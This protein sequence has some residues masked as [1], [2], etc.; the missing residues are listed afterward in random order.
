MRAMLLAL[1]PLGLAA[2]S[3]TVV[4]NPRVRILN[5]NELPHQP[6]KLHKHDFNRVMIYL[7]TADQD[8]S[9]PDA[10]TEHM[11]WKAGDVV[12]SPAG[13]MHMAENVSAG[14]CASWKS[15]SSSPRRR[16]LP[17]APA[18]STRS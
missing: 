14:L 4:D 7:D 6:T 13:G 1:L 2:Q 15:K 5:A 8:I 12:W 17:H 9:H 10:P 16:L 3:T 18:T 11:H